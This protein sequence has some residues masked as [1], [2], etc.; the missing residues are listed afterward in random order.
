MIDGWVL[1]RCEQF[2]H[3]FQ[4]LTGVTCFW[5]G[6]L[7]AVA[8][9][10]LYTLVAIQ[11]LHSGFSTFSQFICEELLALIFAVAL[12][13]ICV[14]EESN[15]SRGSEFCNPLRVHAG[16]VFVRTI[17][18]IN[19]VLIAVLAFSLIFLAIAELITVLVFFVQ[20]TM[21]LGIYFASCTPL[22]PQK[23]KLRE[24]L[25]QAK[26]WWQKEPGDEALPA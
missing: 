11:M 4:Q 5:L 21:T 16:F 7:C 12:F 19:T 1:D 18:V 23:S 9:F 13:I 8:S 15:F 22:P 3:W 17:G 25:E 14:L 10:L 6:K 26:M 20:A 24:W 2:S